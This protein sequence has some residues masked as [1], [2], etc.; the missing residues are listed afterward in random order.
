[1]SEPPFYAPNRPPA[2]PRR[3]QPGEVLFEFVRSSD[4]AP[5]RCELRFHG[6][7]YGWEAQFLE[8]GEL[9]V[10]HG[11]FPLRALTRG[12]VGRGRAEGHRE[13]GA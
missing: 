3:R 13:R 12:A 1:M 4:H 11:G 2:P 10:S 5:M 6:E 9:L 8:R 7:S